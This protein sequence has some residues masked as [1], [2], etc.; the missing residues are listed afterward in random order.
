MSP[1]QTRNKLH[2]FAPSC[3]QESF[4]LCKY[5]PIRHFRVIGRTSC[6]GIKEHEREINQTGNVLRIPHLLFPLQISL[7]RAFSARQFREEEIAGFNK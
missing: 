2:G 7:Q 5:L 6:R 4:H 1:A 3:L